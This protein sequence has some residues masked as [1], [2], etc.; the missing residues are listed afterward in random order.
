MPGDDGQAFGR[1]DPPRL[2]PC[3]AMPRSA[4]VQARVCH[5]VAKRLAG[6]SQTLKGESEVVMR[7]GVLW[8]KSKR[9]LIGAH[10]L[11]K[12]HLLIQHVAQVEEGQRV[13]R[14]GFGSATI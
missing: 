14:I 5:P 11:C 10:R 1:K 2:H 13:L 8:N 4:C 9:P 3:M 7:I 6:L 12:T